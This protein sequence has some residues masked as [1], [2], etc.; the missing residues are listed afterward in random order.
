MLR[1]YGEYFARVYA[2]AADLTGA[3]VVVD[4]SKHASTAY[5]LRRDPGL[6]VRVVH[7]VRDSRGVAYSWTKLMRRPEVDESSDRALMK[8]FP[9]W[10]SALLW[11]AHNAA[12]TSLRWT[13]LPV[14]RVHY[15]QLLARPEEVVMD[16][17]QYLGLGRPRLD[18]ISGTSVTVG[19]THQIAG[20]PM[21]FQGREL[22]LRRDDAWRG[23]L[24]P[25]SRRLVTSL[26]APL[27][28]RYGYL[29]RERRDR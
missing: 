4:S 2:A 6:R 11:D 10:R 24:D 28:V 21:R 15:E 13:G 9:P 18:F 3:S 8:R 22:T 26:T 1:E 25:G 17:A 20:N 7:I 5:I 16:L 23:S 29:R 12:F 19:T 14:R 27:M